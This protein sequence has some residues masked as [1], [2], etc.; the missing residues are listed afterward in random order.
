LTLTQ[1]STLALCLLSKLVAILQWLLASFVEDSKTISFYLKVIKI[2]QTT[3][4]SAQTPELTPCVMGLWHIAA[5]VV[6]LAMLLCNA[7]KRQASNLRL[8]RFGTSIVSKSHSSSRLRS[9]S[10]KV[11]NHMEVE[12]KWQKYWDEHKTFEVKRRPNHKVRYM[13]LVVAALSLL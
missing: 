7:F 8:Q 2:D 13:R 3:G 10:E 4:W 12:Q 5:L 6:G 9:S 11:Y 1:I